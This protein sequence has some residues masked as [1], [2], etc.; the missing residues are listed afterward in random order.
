MH[1]EKK[2]INH[3]PS[4][5]RCSVIQQILFEFPL[6]QVLFYPTGENASERIR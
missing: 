3:N 5:K 2:M 4:T 1:K 6:C